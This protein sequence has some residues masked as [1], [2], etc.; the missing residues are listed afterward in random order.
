M[1]RYPVRLLE[2]DNGTIL[3]D[4]PDIP[5]AHTFGDD[6]EEAKARA[7]DVILTTLEMYIRDRRPIPAPSRA[8]RGGEWV[9]IPPLAGA[10]IS[11]YETMRDQALGKAALAARLGWHLPQVDRVLALRYTSRLDQVQRALRAVGKRVV[12]SV[13]DEPQPPK[14]RGVARSARSRAQRS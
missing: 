8:R 12:L 2:D 5:E 10:K 3:V 7:V 13:E 6:A 1:L 14:R 11:L 4:V 9:E